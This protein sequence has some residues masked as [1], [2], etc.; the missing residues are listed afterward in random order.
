MNSFAY[1][2]C[3]Y[4]KHFSADLLENRLRVARELGATAAVQTSAEASAE[5]LREQLLAAFASEESGAG[6]PSAGPDVTIEC[7]G[8]EASIRL[9]ILVCLAYTL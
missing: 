7:S 8:A 5:E 6:A 3:N 4:L 9:G 2:T 1:V